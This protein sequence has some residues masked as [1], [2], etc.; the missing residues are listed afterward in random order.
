MVVEKRE[1]AQGLAGK[2]LFSLGWLG[3]SVC[4]AAVRGLCQAWVV[5][6]SMWDSF[7]RTVMGW[8]C[9]STLTAAF[10]LRI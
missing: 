3:P 6:C 9:S 2:I 1:V 10:E 4:A 7:L 8:V 5:C